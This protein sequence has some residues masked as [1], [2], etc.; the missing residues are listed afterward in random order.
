MLITRRAFVTAL[1]LSVVAACAQSPTAPKTGVE[2]IPLLQLLKATGY[3]AKA[4][5]FGAGKI[6]AINDDI[7]WNFKVGD[8]LLGLMGTDGAPNLDVAALLIDPTSNWSI[9]R[10]A[11]T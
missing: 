4:I 8:T 10:P 1:P 7:S 9:A 11:R 2:L 5:P 6:I 3:N